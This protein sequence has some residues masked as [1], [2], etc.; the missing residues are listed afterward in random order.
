[1]FTKEE[2]ELLGKYFNIQSNVEGVLL[3]M[4]SKETANQWMLVDF[5]EKFE[6]RYGMYLKK[7]GNKVYSN[8]NQVKALGNVL[9]L[10][11]S[12]EKKKAI[13]QNRY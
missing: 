9:N 7:D 10:I 3:H 13:S 8:F 1:M 5:S 11:S 2:L 6:E 4:D 12:F